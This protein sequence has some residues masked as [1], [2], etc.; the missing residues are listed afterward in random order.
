M[1][2]LFWVVLVISLVL[3]LTPVIDP[4]YGI[5]Y[6]V[7]GIIGMTFCVFLLSMELISKQ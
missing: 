5:H 1:K 7:W 6:T 3:S 4:L 2:T